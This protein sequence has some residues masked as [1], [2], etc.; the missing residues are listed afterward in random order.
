MGEEH[1]VGICH[2]M[3]SEEEALDRERCME[4][5]V[6]EATDATRALA[7]NRRRIDPSRAVKKYRR[8]AAG[9][10]AAEDASSLRTVEALQKTTLYLLTLFREGLEGLD[11]PLHAVYTFVEDRI[12][13]VRQDLT[14][15]RMEI[16]AVPLLE[17]AA[18]FYILSEYVLSPSTTNF[19]AHLNRT[20]LQ[21]CLHT[22]KEAYRRDNGSGAARNS[23]VFLSC[24]LLLGQPL[25]SATL[26][27]AYFC[28]GQ[29][30]RAARSHPLLAQV[31]RILMAVEEGRWKSVFRLTSR[32]D[33]LHKCLLCCYVGPLRRR[34]LMTM[35]K[36]FGKGENVPLADIVSLLEFPSL[37]SAAEVCT[38]L[39]LPLCEDR[40]AALMKTVAIA[41]QYDQPPKITRGTWIGSPNLSALISYLNEHI[42]LI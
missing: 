2:S 25:H 37:D 15:Q 24:S 22:L 21:S 28:Y 31:V 34:S 3:C 11:E 20:Q 6:F 10:K 29:V 27:D 1:I 8:S 13:A 18:R 40:S 14:V 7:Q 16:S 12:R 19:D 38:D 30:S 9:S 35:N 5:S 36:A 26:R 4:V 17:C 32:V 42:S 41:S 39:G 23:D 33:I